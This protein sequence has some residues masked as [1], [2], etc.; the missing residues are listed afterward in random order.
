MGVAGWIAVAIVVLAVLLLAVVLSRLVGP[1]KRM[2]TEVLALQDKVGQ[3]EALQ[4]RVEELTVKME[5]TQVMLAGL[6]AGRADE[7]D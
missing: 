6:S 4:A 5:N 2:Q 7:R 1:L 3:A